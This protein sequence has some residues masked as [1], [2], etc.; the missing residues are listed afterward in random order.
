MIPE[1]LQK[2]LREWQPKFS[3][4]MFRVTLGA[5]FLAAVFIPIGLAASPFIEFFNDM[6]VQPKGKAQGTYGRLYGPPMNVERKPPAGTIP[7]D[8]FPYHNE[9]ETEEDARNAAESIPN[10]VPATMENLRIG[11]KVF[12]VYCRTCHGPTGM[13]DG[14]IVGPGRFPAPPSLHSDAAKK[15][16]DGRIF[17]IITRGQNRMPSLAVQVSPFER[18]CTVHYVRALQRAMDPKPEDFGK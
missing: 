8:W 6:A 11:Q 3:P 17:H 1:P 5:V 14:P 4:T 13:G 15:F 7:M 18:W 2:K 12:T 16:K 9:M 10:P